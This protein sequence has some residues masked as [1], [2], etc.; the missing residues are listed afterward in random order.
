MPG[1]IH[2]EGLRPSDSL[3]RSRA[4]PRKPRSARVGSLARS[5]A[6]SP[7]QVFETVLRV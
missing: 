4:G 5:F 3:T 1:L 6:L 7:V 2:S